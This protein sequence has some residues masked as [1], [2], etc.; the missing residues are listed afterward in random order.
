[1]QGMQNALLSGGATLIN[2]PV[3]NGVEV[4]TSM[5]TNANTDTNF[6]WNNVKIFVG[7]SETP[8]YHFQ[9]EVKAADPGDTLNRGGGTINMKF[10]LYGQGVSM[11][12]MIEWAGSASVS[13]FVLDFAPPVMSVTSNYGMSMILS[14]ASLSL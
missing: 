12:I 4:T 9:Q 8:L 5:S 2:V 13:E 10:F 11:P 14:T 7:A 6:K 3:S 1:M